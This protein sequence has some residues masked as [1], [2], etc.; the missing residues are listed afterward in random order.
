MSTTSSTMIASQ[1]SNRNV[2]VLSGILLLVFVLFSWNIFRVFSDTRHDADYLQIISDMRVLSQQISTHTR[3]ATQGK[4]TAFDE[5]DRVSKQF[6]KQYAKLNDGADG[7]PSLKEELPKE[8]EALGNVWKRIDSSSQVISAN[9]SR[10]LYLH[11]A[12]SALSASIPE[13]QQKYDTVVDA[14][15]D[16]QS[17]PQQVADAEKQRWRAERLARNV[18]KRPPM[19][20]P[21]SLMPMQATLAKY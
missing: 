1:S 21:S 19:L 2:V 10:V 8:I 5:L 13:L 18:D 9:K 14:L 6:G 15:I 3:E 7:L 4:S 17:A 16:S 12:A 20:R 11:E